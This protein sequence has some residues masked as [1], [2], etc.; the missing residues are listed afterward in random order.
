MLQLTAPP[1]CETGPTLARA[2]AEQLHRVVGPVGTPLLTVCGPAKAVADDSL[3]VLVRRQDGEPVAVVKHSSPVSPGAAAEEAEKLRQVRAALPV[4]LAEVLPEVLFGGVADGRTYIA[5]RYYRPVAKTRWR[6]AFQRLALRPRVLAW[7]RDATAATARDATADE[8]EREFRTPLRYVSANAAL[9]DAV[10]LSALKAL[11]RIN[12]GACRPK[13]TLLHNDLWMG[14]LLLPNGHAAGGRWRFVVIDWLGA[15]VDG[16][17]IYDLLRLARS[18]GLRPPAVRRELEMHCRLLGCC[19]NDAECHLLACLGHL[20]MHLGAF[21]E[22]QYQSLVWRS[23]R[24]LQD[25][26]E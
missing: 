13:L 8:V 12:T 9:G 1:R 26:L 16:H 19:V 2:V 10:R 18:L 14:N 23:Y 7:L 11:A 25:V 3:K 21:P 5:L 22:A 4:H 17:G 15:R 20:G 6:R 24:Q